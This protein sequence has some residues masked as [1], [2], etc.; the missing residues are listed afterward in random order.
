MQPQQYKLLFAFVAITFSVP[1]WSWGCS[2]ARTQSLEARVSKLEAEVASIKEQVGRPL[3]SASA[4]DPKIACS[5]AK[6]AAYDAWSPLA[7]AASQA[8]AA[9]SANREH[10]V[11]NAYLLKAAAYSRAMDATTKGALKMRD[12]ARAVP[13]DAS[14]PQIAIAK[15]ASEAAFEA[16]KDL[17]P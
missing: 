8:G 11:A 4:P 2:D 3:T 5:K 1:A 15:A 13:D 6:V 10:D 9:A 16:C 14:K 17:E 7:K 12:A